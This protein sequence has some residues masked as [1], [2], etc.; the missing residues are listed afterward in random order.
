MTDALGPRP[1][2]LMLNFLGLHV[3]GRD[4]AVYSG[5]VIDVFARIGVSEEAA[6]STLTRMAGRGLLT[7][8]RSG[9]KV[10]FGL[11]DRSAEVLAD[12]RRR[13]WDTGAVNDDPGREWTLVGFSLPDNRRGDRHDLR[14]QLGWAGFGLL[15][16]GLWIAAGERDVTAIVD[17]LG[18]GD[19]VTVMTAR[20]SGRTEAADLVR[21]AFDTATIAARYSAFLDTW[22]TPD[23]RQEAPDD[24]ARQ[25]LLHTDWLQAV[26]QDPHLPAR[27]LPA[28]WPAIRAQN[29]FRRLDTD[30][31][32]EAAELA[33]GILDEIPDR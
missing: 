11:T 29:L 20:P 4:V 31:R 1:Q 8:H 22:D 30:F 23:P 28:D 25:L 10:Y 33:A 21:K 16:N 15:Q 18:L 14:T 24:L 19:H 2:S 12:G 27:L 26:R 32:V 17:R 6:R 7:R 5:S 3:L 13:I 9:R